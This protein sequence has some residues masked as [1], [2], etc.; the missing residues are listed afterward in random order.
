[1]SHVRIALGLLAVVATGAVIGARFARAE[2][3]KGGM[4]PAQKAVKQPFVETLVGT[5]NIESTG[6]YAGKGK[7]TFAKGVGGTALLEDY[8]KT[9]AVGTYFGHGIHRVSDDDKTITIWMFDNYGAEPLKLSGP[10]KDTGFE[11]SGDTPGMG[12]MKLTCEKK[13]ES[14]IY[15]MSA[16]G[17]EMTSTYTKAK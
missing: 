11:V 10:L 3:P 6:P 16:G 14:L 15:R 7:A 5:W 9:S 1:M 17:M 12:S 2:D 4:P 8:E 13:G